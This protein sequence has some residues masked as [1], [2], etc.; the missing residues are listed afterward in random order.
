MGDE[1]IIEE[2]P[3]NIV[4]TQQP[5]IQLNIPTKLAGDED[6]DDTEEEEEDDEEETGWEKNNKKQALYATTEFK[7]PLTSSTPSLKVGST[8]DSSAASLS[9]SAKANIFKQLQAI[10]KGRECV[11]GGRGYWN[12]E[13]C[14]GRHVHHVH[15]ERDFETKQVM[16]E[17][18]IILGQWNLKKHKDWIKTQ[19]VATYRNIYAKNP[20][21]TLYFGD[22]DVCFEINKHRHTLVKLRCLPEQKTSSRI[23]VSLT[24][25]TLCSY[26]MTVDSGLL[27][28]LLTDVDEFGVPNKEKFY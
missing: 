17:R 20:S 3:G 23:S 9:E 7:T 10:V 16:V 14:Y 11:K 22:G 5:N 18:R 24:E 13:F 26:V 8:S 4:P 21:I 15:Y 19:Q 12:H 25:P 28:E 27:C 6:V 1:V 2:F